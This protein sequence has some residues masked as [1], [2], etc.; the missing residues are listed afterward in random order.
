LKTKRIVQVLACLLFVY[1]TCFF[2]IYLVRDGIENS[3]LLWD[4][5]EAYL[6]ANW[7]RV[8]YHFTCFEYLVGYIPAL[9]GVNHSYDDIRSSTLVI[10]ITPTGVDR[11]VAER[12]PEN[13]KGDPVG[14]LAYFP[15]GDCLFG[16]DGRDPW[17]CDRTRYTGQNPNDPVRATGYIQAQQRD[18]QAINGWSARHG[19]PGWPARSSIELDDKPIAFLLKVDNSRDEISLKVQLPNGAPLSVLHVDKNLHLVRRMT[20]EYMFEKPRP[21]P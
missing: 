7:S 9:F 17:K 10:R 11:Y 4:S 18:F 8:G 19:L 2:R 3:V 13:P 12:D 21:I 6:F 14:F 15:M 16:F 1:L 20:Y 5:E